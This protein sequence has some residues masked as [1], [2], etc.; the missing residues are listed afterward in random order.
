MKVYEAETGVE[1]TV[2]APNGF[3]YLAG[4]QAGDYRAVTVADYTFI[5]NRSKTVEVDP[6]LSASRR[7]RPWSS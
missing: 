5:L 3:G 4:A 1:R 6:T 7:N 2:T